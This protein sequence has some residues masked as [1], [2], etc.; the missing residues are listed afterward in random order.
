MEGFDRAAYREGFVAGSPS[1]PAP[2]APAPDAPASTA[3]SESTPT[4]PAEGSHPEAP[5]GG[6]TP[7]P[8][9]AAA[10]TT[11]KP[12]DARALA[13]S[14]AGGRDIHELL[15]EQ[16]NRLAAATRELE[17]LKKRA[18]PASETPTDAATDT[19][20]ETEGAT[21]EQP[22]E[23]APVQPGAP[24]PIA[25]TEEQFKEQVLLR[26]NSQPG[27][28]ENLRRW[29]SQRAF[30]AEGRQKLS[31]MGVIWQNGRFHVP[32]L[33]AHIRTMK[34]QLD[35]VK[36]AEAGVL[37]FDELAIPEAQDKVRGL[38]R[39]RA[40]KVAAYREAKDELTAAEQDI[41]TIEA[42]YE[43]LYKAADQE[44]WNALH[45]EATAKHERAARDVRIAENVPK[46][47]AT[48]DQVYAGVADTLQIPKEVRDE[49]RDRVYLDGAF[50]SPAE[51]KDLRAFVEKQT[52]AEIQRRDNDYRRR[53]ERTADLKTADVAGTT[54]PSPSPGPGGQRTAPAPTWSREGHRDSY[55]RGT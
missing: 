9:T 20:T 53:S 7:A 40:D 43:G 28:V 8:E 23:T 26:V 45:A 38:E 14:L 49:I 52:R 19:P 44:L 2:D 46:I 15:V 21:L 55:V 11:D 35:P 25:L 6:T 51:V 1:T 47:R 29:E 41:Q 12:K 27:V 16:N 22:V 34:L 39:L 31:Q 30:V 17:E 5:A 50:A 3:A 13:E 42:E 32:E 54:A 4:T 18:A 33:D 10:P 37:A 36:A 24:V 48:W